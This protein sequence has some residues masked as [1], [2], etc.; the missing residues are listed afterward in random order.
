MK[1]TNYLYQMLQKKMQR[2]I[3][4]QMLAFVDQNMPEIL[5]GPRENKTREKYRRPM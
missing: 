2:V 3:R 4:F 1:P 5:L